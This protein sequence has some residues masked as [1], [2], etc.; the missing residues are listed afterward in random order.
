M[1]SK[2]TNLNTIAKADNDI[3]TKPKSLTENNDLRVF[4]IYKTM[5]MLKLTISCN[6][7]SVRYLK[8]KVKI[9]NFKMSY[10]LK[11]NFAKND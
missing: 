10:D 6:I 4:H 11:C 3:K 2:M 5:S 1:R 8:N 7:F 9:A